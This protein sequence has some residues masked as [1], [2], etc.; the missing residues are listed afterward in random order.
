MADTEPRGVLDTCTYIDL[1][2]ID[3][4]VLPDIPEVTTITMTELHQGV[5]LAKTATTRAKR[6]ERLSSAVEEFDPLPYDRE[7]AGRFGT[8]A[9][10]VV[11]NGRSPKPRCLDLMIAA[12]ASVH[13]IPLYTRTP[14]D[15][16]GLD[17]LVRVISV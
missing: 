17:S 16:K 13:R 5:A 7:S 15:F 9:A 3:P 4:S 10:L 8:L 2:E 11:E 14:S 1:A 12:I 6:I